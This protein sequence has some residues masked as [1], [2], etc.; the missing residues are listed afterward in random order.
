MKNESAQNQGSN[1]L[2]IRIDK[3]RHV[4]I[5]IIIMFLIFSIPLYVVLYNVLFNLNAL[6]LTYFIIMAVVQG[7]MYAAFGIVLWRYVK[8]N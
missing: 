5:S 2:V 8:R 4:Q 1:S 7:I 3:K 6:N